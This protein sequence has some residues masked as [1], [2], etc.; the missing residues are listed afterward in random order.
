MILVFS[1]DIA[2]D[3]LKSD[4]NEYQSNTDGYISKVHSVSGSTIRFLA[5]SF[6]PACPNSLP[7]NE[8]Q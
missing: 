3:R 1:P 4:D 6:C 7:L 2:P 5:G 8:S